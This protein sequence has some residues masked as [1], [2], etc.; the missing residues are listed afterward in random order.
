MNII[1]NSIKNYLSTGSF[2]LISIFVY[3]MSDSNK[4][5]QALLT[6]FLPANGKF[7]AFITLV[8]LVFIYEIG[9][10]HRNAA[11]CGHDEIKEN[12]KSLQ[13][14]VEKGRLVSDVNAAFT[15]FKNSGA[16]H[17]TGEYHIK[18]IHTLHDKQQKLN[19]N[20]YT[21]NKLEHLISKIKHVS[22]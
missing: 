18:E 22:A 11:K 10:K 12:I 15:E 14:V 13:N 8:G 17:I 5:A 4:F 7:L 3:L 2:L 16:E 20:S 1:L 9:L 6:H 19:V 21:Q